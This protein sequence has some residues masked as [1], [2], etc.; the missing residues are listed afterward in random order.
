MEKEGKI[1][2]GEQEEERKG[3]INAFGEMTTDDGGRVLL[4][5]YASSALFS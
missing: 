4:P 3:R 1:L 2:G 5:V